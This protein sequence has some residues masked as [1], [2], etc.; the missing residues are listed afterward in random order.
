M[1]SLILPPKSQ[2]SASVG[3]SERGVRNAL[4][5]HDGTNC[6]FEPPVALQDPLHLPSPAYELAL[7]SQ[8][9]QAN[10]M[11]ADE[12]GTA[13]NIKSRVNR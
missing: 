10:K 9:S 11:L 6:C 4:Q 3:L 12:Y 8:I 7:A 2:V 5:T 1:I 13:S